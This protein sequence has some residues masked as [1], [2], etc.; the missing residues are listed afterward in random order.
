MRFLQTLAIIGKKS[1]LAR[2]LGNEGENMRYLM[3]FVLFHISHVALAF[4]F[5]PVK[6]EKLNDHIYAMM[7]SRDIP[8]K[9]NGGYVNNTLVVIGKQGV[10]LVDPGSHRAVAEHIFQSIKTLTS[11][12]VTHIIVTHYHAD[13]SLGVQY[14]HD[15]KLIATEFC[16]S[17]IKQIGFGMVKSMRRM[18][19][20]AIEDEKPLIPDITIPALATREMEIEGVRFNLI[21]TETAHTPGDLIVWLPDDRV[22]ATGDIL[23]N[24]VNPNFNDGNLKSWLGVI[25]NRILPLPFTIVMPGH[26]PLMQRDD[27]VNFQRLISNFYKTVEKIYLNDGDESDVRKTIDI[28]KWKRMARFESMMGR[29]ISKVWLEVEQANF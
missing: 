20:L 7:G 19:G 14:Y 28:D 8:N 21:S 13:H 5:P 23:V 6:V 11:K 25:K 29:N 17:K 10:I 18:T 22:L 15:I 1:R 27:V 26:G 3:I 2:C 12:P 9:E 24:K 4:D 16:A